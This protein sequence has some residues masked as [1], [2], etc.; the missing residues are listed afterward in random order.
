MGGRIVAAVLEELASS[1][2]RAVLFDG[3]VQNGG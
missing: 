2:L 1:T 3:V